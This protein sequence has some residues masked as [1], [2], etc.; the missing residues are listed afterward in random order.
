MFKCN[1]SCYQYVS[2]GDEIPNTNKGLKGSQLQSTD[3][4]MLK[5]PSDRKHCAISPHY[6]HMA[7]WGEVSCVTHRTLP[8]DH[9][10]PLR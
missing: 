5:Y 6:L 10:H 3:V 7:L 8:R 9:V 2:P 1:D 4:S